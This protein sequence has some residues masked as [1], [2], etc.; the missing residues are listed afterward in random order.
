MSAKEMKKL[1]TG[2][3]Q[4]ISD[5]NA[6]IM[7]RHSKLPFIL[8]S[9]MM[10]FVIFLVIWANTSELEI[11]TRGGGE[12]V[13]STEVQV[14]QNLEGGIIA[15]LNAKEGAHVSKGELL[16]KLDNSKYQSAYN[17]MK[18]DQMSLEAN[19][20]RLTA[21]LTA[22]SEVDFPAQLSDESDLIITQKR[23][24]KSRMDHYG[25]MVAGYSSKVKHLYLEVQ[26]QRL[27][28]IRLE[29]ELNKHAPVFPKGL[30][31][32]E[33]I[34][35]KLEQSLFDSRKEIYEA[36][37][38]ALKSNQNLIKEELAQAKELL[39]SG[40]ASMVEVLRLERQV[41]DVEGSLQALESNRLSEITTGIESRKQRLVQLEGVM[42]DSESQLTQFKTNWHNEIV[43]KLAEYQA[44]LTSTKEKIESLNDT[45]KRTRIVSPVNGTINT[46]YHKNVGGVINPGEPIME[47]IPDDDE[48]ML[49]GMISPQEVAFLRKGMPVVIK[50]MAYDYGS[51]GGLDGKLIHISADTHKDPNTG[52]PFY[53]VLVKADKNYLGSEENIIIPGMTA[54]LDIITGKRTVLNY[55]ISP[56]YNAKSTT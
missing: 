9:L 16:V 47:I 6:A 27:T 50:I 41:T 39:D 52:M 4:F 20:A 48:L 18:A 30:E 24:F 5:L 43:N 26:E 15:T 12:A 8:I 49:E 53:K 1:Q 54:Q 31:G 32:K 28:L 45:V 3:E 17:E 44:S 46:V 51:Y 19:I 35:F 25:A 33:E 10:A 36:R 42:V 11:I 14:I 13:P 56:I 2:D 38:A 55:F 34:I 40:A 22:Q 29:A 7:H 37:K 23:L 21:E